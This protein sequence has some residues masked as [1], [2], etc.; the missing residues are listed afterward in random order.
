MSGVRL[1]IPAP[2]KLLTNKKLTDGADTEGNRF[3]LM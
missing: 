2:L 1:P 3:G